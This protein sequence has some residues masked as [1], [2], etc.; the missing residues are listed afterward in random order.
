[1]APALLDLVAEP[2]ARLRVDSIRVVGGPTHASEG[3]PKHQSRHALGIR[4]RKQQRRR[5]TLGDANH[6]GLLAARSVHHG[7]HVVHAL[8]EGGKLRAAIGSPVP[9]LSKVIIRENRD[10]RRYIN[11]VAGVSQPNST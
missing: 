9:R 1:M 7:P 3:P 8:L 4:R 2:L 10:S 5:A 6:R 11:D